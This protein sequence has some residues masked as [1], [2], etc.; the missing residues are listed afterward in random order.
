MS[1]KS[2]RLTDIHPED[3]LQ[4]TLDEADELDFVLIF[5]VSKKGERVLRCTERSEAYFSLA[6]SHCQAAAHREIEGS[7]DS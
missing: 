2:N 6:A 4:D 5:T 3:L 7:L 1:K